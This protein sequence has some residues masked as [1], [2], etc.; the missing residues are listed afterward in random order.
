MLRQQSQTRDS[1]AAIDRHIT[2]IYTIELTTVF[3]QLLATLN[4]KRHKMMTTIAL[5]FHFCQKPKFSF[6][7]NPGKIR[8]TWAKLMKMFAKYLKF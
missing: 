1:L 8:K 7:K 2:I 5:A 4:C 6:V 3:I